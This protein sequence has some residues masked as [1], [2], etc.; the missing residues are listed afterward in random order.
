MK[1]NLLDDYV[2][3]KKERKLFF[4]KYNAA[5]RVLYSDAMI[6]N[7]TQCDI[8]EQK[9][10]DQILNHRMEY[11]NVFNFLSGFEYHHFLKESDKIKDFLA[12]KSVRNWVG[13]D[14]AERIKITQGYKELCLKVWEDLII[15]NEEREALDRYCLEN[16]I[17]VITKKLIEDSVIKTINKS[18][19]NFHDIV[20]YYYEI[21]GKSSEQIKDL[22][23]SEY[24]VTLD[25]E[26]INS[27]IIDL[28]KKVIDSL[29]IDD[30][31]KLIYTLKFGVTCTIYVIGVDKPLRSSMEFDIGYVNTSTET[32][33]FKILL[34]NST[35][36]NETIEGLINIISD[37][38]CYKNTIDENLNTFLELKTAVKATVKTMLAS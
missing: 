8:L 27:Q 18:G 21:E 15:T 38:I 33:S 14:H 31:S 24:K 9:I 1:Q 28:N 23:L 19:L 29:N 35:I 4:K 20:K 30:R 10:I 12:K 2:R 37:A 22:L 26:K 25:L 6:R 13:Y 34:S 5:E 11:H 7:K 16:K 17:D 32:D 36:T 3:E